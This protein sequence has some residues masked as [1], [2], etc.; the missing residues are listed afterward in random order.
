MANKMLIV[1]G[2]NS[3]HKPNSCHNQKLLPPSSQR[4]DFLYSTVHKKV[5]HNYVG[6]MNYTK[7]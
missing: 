6:M 4:K 7:A 2:D 3:T 5:A 1:S